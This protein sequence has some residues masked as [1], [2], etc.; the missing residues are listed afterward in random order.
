MITSMQEI[1]AQAQPEE[2]TISGFHSGTEL[3]VELRT[4]SLYALLAENA[5]PNPLLPVVRKLFRDGPKPQDVADP[6]AEFANA[7]RTIARETLVKPS[8]AE[9][10]ENGVQLTDCQLLEICIY[11]TRGPASLAIF[12]EGVSTAAA[13]NEPRVSH[14]AEPAAAPD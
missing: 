6:D 9:L 10:N 3:T 14:A 11:A 7:L 1:I 12:R 4:P 2:V 8:L 5:L 13:A